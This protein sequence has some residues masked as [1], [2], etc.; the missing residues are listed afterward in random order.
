MLLA[1]H[2]LLGQLLAHSRR[3][4]VET[5]LRPDLPSQPASPRPWGGNTAGQ[6]QLRQCSPGKQNMV[7][8]GKAPTKSTPSKIIL[9]RAK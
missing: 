5:C 9:T 7:E 6:M 2:Q 3:V 8:G 4:I 1:Y